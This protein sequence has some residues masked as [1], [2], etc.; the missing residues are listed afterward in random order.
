MRVAVRGA[1]CKPL[2]QPIEFDGVEARLLL[3]R[4]REASDVLRSWLEPRSRFQAQ[5]ESLGTE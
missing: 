4:E 2:A 5:G 1:L 3:Q